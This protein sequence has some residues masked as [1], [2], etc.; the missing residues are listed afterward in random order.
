MATEQP[1]EVEQDYELGDPSGQATGFDDLDTD[2]EDAD[3]PDFL[4]SNEEPFTE[5]EQFDTLKLL[6]NS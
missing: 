3:M 1:A 4:A 6:K 2:D 5:M